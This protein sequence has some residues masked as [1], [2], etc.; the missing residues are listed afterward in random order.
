MAR[1]ASHPL[2]TA[3]LSTN[4]TT[5][6][7]LHTAMLDKLTGGTLLVVA[8]HRTKKRE[9]ASAVKQLDTVEAKLAGFALHQGMSC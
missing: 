4:C 3:F 2:R 8:S 7:R 9:L 6:L 5:P 1:P